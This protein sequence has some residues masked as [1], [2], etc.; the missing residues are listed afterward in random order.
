VQEVDRRVVVNPRQAR[1]LLTAVTYVGTYDRA[2]GRRL[3]ALFGCLY[4][5]ALRPGEALGSD[6]RTALFRERV[7]VASS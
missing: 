4:Y 1:E 6:A 2:S 3:R 5:A 7:G